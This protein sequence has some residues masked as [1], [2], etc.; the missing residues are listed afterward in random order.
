MLLTLR[1]A[2]SLQW[3]LIAVLGATTVLC[4]ACLGAYGLW[5]AEP[6]YWRQSQGSSAHAA[7][8]ADRQA[9]LALERKMISLMTSTPRAQ[10]IGIPLS[11]ANAWLRGRLGEWV[12]HR[13]T[14]D[15]GD[16]PKAGG[17]RAA[18][19]VRACR[20]M[21]AIHGDRLVLAFRLPLT[22][23]T[24]VHSLVFEPA[25]LSPRRVGLRLA[26]ARMGRL[27]LPLTMVRARLAPIAGE[28]DRTEAAWLTAALSGEPFDPLNPTDRD[29][30][31]PAWRLTDLK[32]SGQQ[33]DLAFDAAAP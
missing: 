5:H 32:L 3:L 27:P 1:R 30:T 12:S 22:T 20:P 13:D 15:D 14:A 23:A 28:L 29:G 7:T 11:A 4:G 18:S 33:V 8:G 2:G 21:L 26:G 16:D 24:T 6:A 17:S 25:V 31:R 10:R 9:A 19:I